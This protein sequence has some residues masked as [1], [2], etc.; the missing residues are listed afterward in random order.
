MGFSP[1]Q[2]ANRLSDRVADAVLESITA[3]GLHQGDRL[4]TERE[5][6]AQ[7]GVSR[8]VVRE[9]VRSLVAKEIVDARPG[10]GLTV[11]AP[12]PDTARQSIALFLRG[13]PE[14]D[15][16]KVDEVR[17]LLETEVVALAAARATDAE[18]AA[19]NGVCDEM[20][21]RL[22][23]L[24]EASRLDVE[25][26]RQIAAAT[27]NEL[28]LLM[29]DALADSLIEI[30]RS[31]FRLPGRP[32]VA[33]DAH[34]AIAERIAAADADGARAAMAEHLRDVEGVWERLRAQAGDAPDAAL[35]DAPGTVPGTSS[36]P[37]SV[38]HKGSATNRTRGARIGKEH[39]HGA[40]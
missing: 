27:H 11:S 12:E 7:F 22:R 4:P 39:G 35:G 28:Y 31:T 2:R 13:R 15:Y 20:A 26:H 1:L 10:R 18:R 9:A 23:D 40:L 19:L 5:L 24:T 30:R 29:L 14:T 16:R 38:A 6:A 36:G 21:S 25:F 3:R 34:R 8:T 17:R 37:V 32:R 33:L